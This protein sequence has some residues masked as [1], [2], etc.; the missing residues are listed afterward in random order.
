[1]VS[2]ARIVKALYIPCLAMLI[3]F[4]MYM[5]TAFL[6]KNW[7]YP[8]NEHLIVPFGRKS[9]E[10]SR[11]THP[12]LEGEIDQ[13]FRENPSLK[14]AGYVIFVVLLSG[15]TLLIWRLWDALKKKSCG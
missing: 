1:M 13:V 2:F 12:N 8:I 5:L 10:Q 11:I 6:P 3:L 14:V 15:N 9:Y 4:E 7:Q